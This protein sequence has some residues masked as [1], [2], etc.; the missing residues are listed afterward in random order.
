[1]PQPLHP[2]LVHFPIVLIITV[3]VFHILYLLFPNIISAKITLIQLAMGIIGAFISA[4]SGENALQDV[5]PFTSSDIL[6][7][8]EQHEF[9]AN[10]TIWGGLIVLISGTYLRLKFE[11]LRW[12]DNIMVARLIMLTI[13][14]IKTAFLGAEL[15]YTYHIF[16]P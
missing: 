14:V 10:L 16:I 9:W 1:M 7:I 3:L 4:W 12:I 6:G 11:N 2:A 15:V 13:F 5:Q 8:V